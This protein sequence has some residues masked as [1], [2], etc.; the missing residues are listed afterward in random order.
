MSTISL[1]YEQL[2]RI[3]LHLLRRIAARVID[4]FV[5]GL[6]GWGA[7]EFLP[8]EL[9]GN[10]GWIAGLL[11]I[12]LYEYLSYGP[13]GRGATFGKWLLQLRVVSHEGNQL[14]TIHTIKRALSFAI[15]MSATAMGEAAMGYLPV[16]WGQASYT[17]AIV[18][19]LTAG[20]ISIIQILMNSQRRSYFDLLSGSICIGKRELDLLGLPRVGIELYPA[21]TYV[22]DPNRKDVARAGE[23][24]VR[25]TWWV[26]PLL[27]FLVAAVKIDPIVGPKGDV[28]SYLRMAATVERLPVTGV[29]VYRAND[30]PFRF[31]DEYP[32]GSIVVRARPYAVTKATA[33]ELLRPISFALW[34]LAVPAMPPNTA[35]QLVNVTLITGG[36]LGFTSTTESYQQTFTP[37]LV[38]D[39]TATPTTSEP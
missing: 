7:L 16:R 30:I 21:S 29:V 4:L 3:L 34:Q 38:N 13:V 23:V 36:T 8:I 18:V 2:S 24:L 37:K 1:G 17:A 25:S 6:L 31:D 9:L 19:L 10:N 33:N 11:L 27:V 20:F 15:P 28:Q 26:L 5:V 22:S 32:P 14:D 39:S 12:G 35:P